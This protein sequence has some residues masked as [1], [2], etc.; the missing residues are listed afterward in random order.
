MQILTAH[1]IKN[2]YTMSHLC[3]KNY[4]YMSRKKG[5]ETQTKMWAAVSSCQLY[6]LPFSKKKKSKIFCTFQVV[7]QWIHTTF[8]I[9]KTEKK[10]NTLWLSV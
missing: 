9:N 8:T 6:E 1:E 2:R 3:Q 4:P 5:Q 7:S 10:N